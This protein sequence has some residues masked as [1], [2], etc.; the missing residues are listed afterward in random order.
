MKLEAYTFGLHVGRAKI[1][2]MPLRQKLWAYN[3]AE[4]KFGSHLGLTNRNNIIMTNKVVACIY[5]LGLHVSEPQE[6]R[7]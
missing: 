7:R 5:T 3:R 4:I 6:D 2:N 1:E